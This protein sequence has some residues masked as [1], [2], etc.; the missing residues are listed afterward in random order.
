MS[1]KPIYFP[2][3]KLEME[4]LSKKDKR[5]A[6]RIAQIG[7]IDREVTPD[8]FTALISSIVGQQCSAKAAVTVWNR[9][10]AC[11]GV[12]TP[13]AIAAL[14]EEDIQNCGMS[15]RK[16]GYIHSAARYVRDGTL[17]MDDLHTLP[18]HE[19]CARL[20][21][22]PGVGVWTAEMLMIFSLQRP[23]IL[24]WDDLAIRRGLECLYGHKKLTKVQFERY[25][26]RYTPYATVASFYLWEI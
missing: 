2:Y 19:V 12:I 3:G 23:N 26:K 11:A 24:S 21:V 5:L 14:S 9:L 6:E 15:F 20:T 18:D 22:L 7:H 1:S 8:L 13:Q 4:Y 25:K 17:T 10:Q 16:A